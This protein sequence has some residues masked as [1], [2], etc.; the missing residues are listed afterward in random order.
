MIWIIIFNIKNSEHLR[1]PY[2][3]NIIFQHILFSHIS[4]KSLNRLKVCQLSI[5]VETSTYTIE[6]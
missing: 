4:Y 2:K 6:V 1:I 3:I 5:A